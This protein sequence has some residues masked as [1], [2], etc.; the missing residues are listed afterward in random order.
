M[1]VRPVGGGGMSA[2]TERVLQALARIPLFSLLP[3]PELLALGQHLRGR[4]YEKGEAIVYLGDEGNT[5][6]LIRSGTVKV[7]RLSESGREVVVG[8]LDA[9]QFFGE[10]ALLDGAPRSASVYAIEPTEVLILSREVFVNYLLRYPTA[11]IEVI[12]VLSDRVRRLNEQ[13]EQA[14]FMDLPQRLARQLIQLAK[15]QGKQTKEG[16]GIGLALTQ[17]DLAGMVGASRQ[18]VNGLLGEWRDRRLI[19]LGAKG[20]LTILEPET[21]Q[22]IAHGQEAVTRW[23]GSCRSRATKR[24]LRAARSGGGGQGVGLSSGLPALKSRLR[25]A[26]SVSRVT[27]LSS[28]IR[29]DRDT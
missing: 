12:R 15:R 29:D 18:R 1:E 19:R 3:Q 8:V 4:R 28:H 13:L 10:M 14:Y 9:G 17:S 20:E 7:T 24:V 16:I 27:S 22:E 21:L 2:D 23:E 25:N 11:A 26:R 6:F 5:F